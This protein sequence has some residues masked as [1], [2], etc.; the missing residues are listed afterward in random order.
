MSAADPATSPSLSLS[1]RLTLGDLRQFIEDEAELLDQKRFRE[2]LDLFAEDAIYWVPAKP[3]QESAQ[4]YVSLFYDDKPTMRIRVERL[5]HA[6]IHIQDP[7]S[8][9]VRVLSGFRSRPAEENPS[10]YVVSSKFVMIEDRATAAQRVF[11]GRYTHTLR[12]HGG[13]LKIVHKR[14]D[15]TNCNQTFPALTQPF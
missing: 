2:W 6:R 15:L 9:T 8:L 12:E 10:N 1:G 4:D 7:A 3:G 11:G 13:T 14:V 5:L